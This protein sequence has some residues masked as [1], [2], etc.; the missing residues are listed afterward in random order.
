MPTDRS[1]TSIKS[2]ILL[3]SHHAVLLAKQGL[4]MLIVMTALYTPIAV[5]TLLVWPMS[6]TSACKQSLIPLDHFLMEYPMVD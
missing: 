4:S 6:P 2:L 1:S 5:H 3:C